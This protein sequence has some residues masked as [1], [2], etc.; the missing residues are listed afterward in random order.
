MFE[1]K[2]EVLVNGNFTINDVKS[3]IK[4]SLD[5][6]INIDLLHIRAKISEKKCKEWII[7]DNRKL[8]KFGIPF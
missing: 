3:N 2:M 7:D 8:P 4:D 6:N 1:I 5:D